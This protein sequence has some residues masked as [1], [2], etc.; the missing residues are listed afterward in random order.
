M[1]IYQLNL[2]SNRTYNVADEIEDISKTLTELTE[3]GADKDTIA[4]VIDLSQDIVDIV[5]NTKNVTDN[6]TKVNRCVTDFNDE[7][8][9]NDKENTGRE[10]KI[11]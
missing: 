8:G 1:Y 10:R 5:E 4:N 6:G 11:Y 2:L 3:A 9:R 7:S